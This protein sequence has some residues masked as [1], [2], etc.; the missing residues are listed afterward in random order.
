MLPHKYCI[1]LLWLARV[2]WDCMKS[3]LTSTKELCPTLRLDVLHI[4]RLAVE[5]PICV[6]KVEKSKQFRDVMFDRPLCRFFNRW[7]GS[8]DKFVWDFYCEF[9]DEEYKA[10]ILQQS[11]S[12]LSFF[13]VCT[14][15]HLLFY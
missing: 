4:A 13:P 12:F 9:R 1:P 6:R 5:F 7:M 8:R 3:L 11:T 15:Y 10:D 14:S 2:Q